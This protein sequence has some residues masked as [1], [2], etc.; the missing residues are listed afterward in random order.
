MADDRVLLI[1]VENAVGPVAP[2]AGVVRSRVRALIDAAG[3]PHHV[4]ACYA[5]QDP[6]AD[7]TVSVLAEMGVATWQVA[8]GVD[9]AD[10][11]LIQHARYLQGRGFTTFVVASG[12]GVFALLAKLGRLEV[13]VWEPQPLSRRLTTAA[14]AVRRLPLPPRDPAAE[15]QPPPAPAG[16]PTSPTQIGASESDRCGADVPRKP[17]PKKTARGS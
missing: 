1:D 15:P 16:Q 5:P 6:Q 17:K 14:H 2:G 13:L 7:R 9:A 10:H 4:L 3:E 11:A 12:D 8:K